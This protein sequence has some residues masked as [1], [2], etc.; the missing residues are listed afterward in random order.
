MKY[1]FGFVIFFQRHPC[2]ARVSIDDDNIDALLENQ[3]AW[4]IIISL[5]PR[6]NG[7][8]LD[9]AVRKAAIFPEFQH[10][11]W[12]NFTIGIH[13][14]Q[15]LYSRGIARIAIGG[16]KDNFIP[17][18]VINVRGIVHFTTRFVLALRHGQVNELVLC[19]IGL[20]S[21][22]KSVGR[23]KSDRRFAVPSM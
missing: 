14:L 23:N 20:A 5:A 12:Y 9:N 11:D 13:S 17:N 21:M 1:W 22:S 3:F 2:Y 19:V 8:L 18:I 15:R 16:D 7:L 10:V 6:G 4:L